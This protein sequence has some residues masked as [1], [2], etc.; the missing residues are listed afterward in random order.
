MY[1][2]G[3]KIVHLGMSSLTAENTLTHSSISLESTISHLNYAFNEHACSFLI[4][5]ICFKFSNFQLITFFETVQ[6]NLSLY[7]DFILVYID[8]QLEQ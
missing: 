4:K 8:I 6:V 1:Y 2:R 3:L 5:I 7:F